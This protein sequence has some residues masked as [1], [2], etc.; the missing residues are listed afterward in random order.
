MALEQSGSD[1]REPEECLDRVGR[2]W[3]RV[4]AA[5]DGQRRATAPRPVFRE[6]GV[7]LLLEPDDHGQGK[8]PCE[9]PLRQGVAEEDEGNARGAGG[10]Q[11]D[12]MDA[13]TGTAEGGLNGSQ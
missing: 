11:V 8:G 9:A 5:L 2:V 1:Q 3:A 4:L 10:V 12:E 6:H 13:A 7:E